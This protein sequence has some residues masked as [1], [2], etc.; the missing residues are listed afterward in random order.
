V[1]P[2]SNILP[3]GPIGN[4]NLN[5]IGPIGETEPRASRRAVDHLLYE[6]RELIEPQYVKWFAKRFYVLP[7]DTIHRAASEAKQDGNNPKRLF[8][9]IINKHYNAKSTGLQPN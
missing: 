1:Q 3:I 5:P 4:K 7:Y 9:F 8:S 2:V 6:Y